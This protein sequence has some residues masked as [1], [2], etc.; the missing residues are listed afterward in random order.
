MAH[1]PVKM[2]ART[3]KQESKIDFKGLQSKATSE[4][5]TDSHTGDLQQSKV[6]VCE[7][8]YVWSIAY[9]ACRELNCVGSSSA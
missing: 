7:E 6:C 1:F 5:A 8:R 9:N 2:I 3:C 4:D